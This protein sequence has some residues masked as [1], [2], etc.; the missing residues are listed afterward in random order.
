MKVLKFL[1]GGLFAGSLAM[2]ATG[3]A[4]PGKGAVIEVVTLKLEKA[5]AAA[6]FMSKIAASTMSMKRC[7]K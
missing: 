3:A 1:L 5:P 6:S 7:Q 2:Q 4:T